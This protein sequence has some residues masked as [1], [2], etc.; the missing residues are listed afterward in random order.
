MTMPV[1]PAEWPWRL[2]RASVAAPGMLHALAAIGAWGLW[3]YYELTGNGH[4]HGTF[5][6]FAATMAPEPVSLLA[7]FLLVARAGWKAQRGWVWR[8]AGAYLLAA[9]ALITEVSTDNYQIQELTIG[10]GCRHWYFNWPWWDD[11]WVGR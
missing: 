7:L 8:T 1:H 9:G 5:W 2:L 4:N 6:K 11:R 3:G 10:E